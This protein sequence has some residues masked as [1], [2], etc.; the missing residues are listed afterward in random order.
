MSLAAIRTAI[1]TALDTLLTTA[2]PAGPLA[3]VDNW[4]GEFAREQTSGG[5]AL[6]ALGEVP[7]ALIAFARETPTQTKYTTTGELAQTLATLWTIFVV[8]SDTRAPGD[9]AAQLDSVLD[10][11]I[12]AV[13]GVQVTSVGAIPLALESVAPYRVRPGS[14]C[15]AITLRAA[16][17]LT[18]APVAGDTDPFER[19]DGEVNPLDADATDDAAAL[20]LANVRA[21]N[22]DEL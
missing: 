11:V 10:A 5:P 15:Y 20:P 14:Y 1:R 7:A 13:V 21:D 12:D 3:L 2:D 9:A 17:V 6:D 16:R 19:F 18:T 4:A 22:L 8:T